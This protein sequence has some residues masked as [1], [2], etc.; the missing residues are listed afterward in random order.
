MREQVFLNRN[1]ILKYSKVTLEF[2]YS[3]NKTIVFIFIL[4]HAM[5]IAEITNLKVCLT[6]DEKLSVTTCFASKGSVLFC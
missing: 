3:F 1:E 2:A 4:I 6:P 5:H